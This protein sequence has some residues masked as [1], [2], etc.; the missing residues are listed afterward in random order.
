MPGGGQGVRGWAVVGA[1]GADM[2]PPPERDDAAELRLLSVSVQVRGSRLGGGP[3]A[4]GVRCGAV[5]RGPAGAP[6]PSAARHGGRPR[7]PFATSV[8]PCSVPQPGLG[9]GA[10]RV[11]TGGGGPGPGRP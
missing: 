4:A 10:P 8:P 1:H 5:R 6:P 7:F 2:E 3:E 9:D 11:P